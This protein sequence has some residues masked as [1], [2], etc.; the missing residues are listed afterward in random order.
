M[1]KVISI[2]I[3]VSNSLSD[4]Y[5]VCFPFFRSGQTYFSKYRFVMNAGMLAGLVAV[6][7]VP[8][9]LRVRHSRACVMTRSYRN[10]VF[11]FQILYSSLITR[12]STASSKDSAAKGRRL[13]TAVINS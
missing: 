13:Y 5:F 12:S 2:S 6:L 8:S 4:F 1:E 9:I 7:A 11:F 3:Y 10:G